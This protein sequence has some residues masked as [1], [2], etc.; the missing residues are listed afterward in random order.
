M[1]RYREIKIKLK[2][3]Y[4]EVSTLFQMLNRHVIVSGNRLQKSAIAEY[5][6]KKHLE[7]NRK[8]V[9]RKDQYSIKFTATDAYFFKLFARDIEIQDQWEHNTILRIMMEIDRKSA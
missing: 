9:A 7:L 8:I 5:I 2:L 1:D 4:N 3:S 6:I